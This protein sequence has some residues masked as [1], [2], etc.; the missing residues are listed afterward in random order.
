MYVDAVLNL[1][2]QEIGSCPNKAHVQVIQS[3][4]AFHFTSSES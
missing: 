1:R 3:V 4:S 2:Q